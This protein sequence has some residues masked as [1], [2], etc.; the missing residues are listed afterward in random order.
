MSD[1]ED[2]MAEPIH[3]TIARLVQEEFSDQSTPD[4]QYSAGWIEGRAGKHFV[5][6]LSQ[7]SSTPDRATEE[8]CAEIGFWHAVADL[9]DHQLG[10]KPKPLP[11]TND[12][13]S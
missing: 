11:N 5:H 10:R 1:T 13:L 12:K 6:R 3:P 4:L 7:L 8:L 9:K 2:V